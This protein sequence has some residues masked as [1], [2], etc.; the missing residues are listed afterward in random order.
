VTSA[1]RLAHSYVAQLT[2]LVLSMSPGIVNGAALPG[3]VPRI[4]IDLHLPPIEVLWFPTLTDAAVVTG[5][6]L[7]AELAR[8]FDGRKIYLATLVA[9]LVSSAITCAAPNL[10]ALIFGQVLHGLATGFFLVIGIG[11]VLSNFGAEKIRSTVGILIAALFGAGSLGPLAATLGSLAPQAWRLLFAAEIV[12]S[13]VALLLALQ[14]LPARPAKRVSDYIDVPAIVL[15]LLSTAC[16][17]AGV[18]FFENL[19]ASDP[20]V[21]LPLL[22]GNAALAALFVVEFRTKDPLLPVAEL[23]RVIPFVA[24]LCC[25][26]GS[27]GYAGAIACIGA[28]L[29]F[30]SGA[31]GFAVSAP[32][33]VAF[34][35]AV[36]AGVIFSRVVATRWWGPAAVGGMLSLSAGALLGCTLRLDSPLAF[37][38][39]TV[40]VLSLGAGLTIVP[41]VLTTALSVLPLYVGRAI[42][43][44][45]MLRMDA[46]YLT[47][48]AMQSFVALRVL[49]HTG[50]PRQAYLAAT[51]DGCALVALLSL[52]VACFFVAVFRITGAHL[53]APRLHCLLDGTGVGIDSPELFPLHVAHEAPAGAQKPN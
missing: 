10:G 7:S 42:A 1:P 6:I 51:H 9:S 36:L 20:H 48:P 23:R 52:L 32:L 11:P 40:L 47:G 50:T 31:R 13:L 17:F 3:L 37:V 34:I 22:A 4:A 28:L 16:L 38:A 33:A 5:S 15:A 21:W 26:F 46:S 30:A 53:E 8:H 45:A 18:A 35:G 25:V 39:A 29:S 2:L 14:A 19:S 49:A 41:G 43:L 12:M 27:A 24:A 44:L